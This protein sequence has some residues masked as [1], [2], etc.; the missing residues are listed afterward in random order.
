[1]TTRTRNILS[2]ICLWYYGEM[3]LQKN[4][5]GPEFFST[6]GSFSVI[7]VLK[8]GKPVCYSF[9]INITTFT[10]DFIKHNLMCLFETKFT[11]HQ[12]LDTSSACS[13]AIGPDIGRFLALTF[14]NHSHTTSF[15]IHFH[16]TSLSILFSHWFLISDLA[17]NTSYSD[18]SIVKLCLD[19]FHCQLAFFI[20]FSHFSLLG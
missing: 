4:C 3:C 1:M 18:F 8:F 12:F 6:V 7:Q 15:C 5:K 11:L 20:S 9:F 16:F 10:T 14:T 17:F 19:L 2:H 13:R